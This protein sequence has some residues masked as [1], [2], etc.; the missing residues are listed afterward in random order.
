MTSEIVKSNSPLNVRCDLATGRFPFSD[1]LFFFVFPGL[2][3][4][5]S[6]T[7][8]GEIY[9]TMLSTM[10]AARPPSCDPFGFLP[11]PTL[12]E[13]HKLYSRGCDKMVFS[14]SYLV[15]SPFRFYS[16]RCHIVPKLCFPFHRFCYFRFQ[17]CDALPIS[18]L[19]AVAHGS[20]WKLFCMISSSISC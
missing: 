7:L 1:F 8:R 2:S 16:Q 11:T 12:S 18:C 15:P 10:T 14:F 6:L 17:R 9:F 5:T 19:C 13:R 4:H 20:S 3:P